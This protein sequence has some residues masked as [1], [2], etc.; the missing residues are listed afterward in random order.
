MQALPEELRGDPLV[1]AE[2][3]ISNDRDARAGRRTASSRSCHPRRPRQPRQC[4]QIAQQPARG[5]R[6]STSKHVGQRAAAVG[7]FDLFQRHIGFEFPF[8]RETDGSQANAW[9]WDDLD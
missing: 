6:E 9:G 8:G 4:D 7:M 3:G 1:R 5:V 2:A